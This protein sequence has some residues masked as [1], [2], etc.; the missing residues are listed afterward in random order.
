MS[1]PPVPSFER[2]P[3]PAHQPVAQAE[4]TRRKNTSDYVAS[5]TSATPAKDGE[6]FSF[7][8]LVDIVNPLQHIPVVNTIYRK[9]TGDEIHGF[10]RVAGGAVFGGLLGAA[11]GTVNAVVAMKDGKDI[12]DNVWA[13]LTG[14]KETAVA[15]KKPLVTVTPEPTELAGTTAAS[16]P[17]HSSA[18]LFDY[19]IPAKKAAAETEDKE[20][21]SNIPVIEIRPQE[22]SDATNEESLPPAAEV[23]GLNDIMPGAPG[24]SA[25]TYNTTKETVV[26]PKDKAAIQRA[27]MDAL[28][29][30]QEMEEDGKEAE[31]ENAVSA[32]NVT[33]V[34]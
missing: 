2:V 29:K 10:A 9:I 6:S 28:I 14:E 12:G 24:I 11:A 18:A 22:K 23:S 30:M 3:V 1:L 5:Q 16:V 13:S 31:S 8:D 26:D 17:A 20:P 15:A 27:M 7:W 33:P 21:V 32:D 34:N 25:A 4:S 19:N